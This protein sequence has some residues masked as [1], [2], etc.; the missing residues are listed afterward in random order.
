M[1]KKLSKQ[2][3]GKSN[4][5]WLESRF[6]FSFAEYRNPVNI[7][8]GVLRVLND[9]IVYPH[10]GFDMHPHEN[11]EIISYIV[12]GEITHKDSM[13][14]SEIL[15]RGEVQYLSAGDGIYHSEKNESNK[16]LR[17][18]QIWVFPPK[19]GLPR[20][21]GSHKY[22]LEEREN[23]LLNIVS[24]QNGESSIKIYQDINIYVSELDKSLEFNIDENRQIYFVQIEGTA[25]INGILL[26]NGD[27]MELVDEK[28]LIINPISKSHI[29]FIEMKK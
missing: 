9:D 16:D 2:N 26:E 12:D 11:M 28:Q 1:L 13:G 14:N 22:K 18:L 25:T 7:Q 8:F 23:R 3:M 20:L 15:K 24:S 4:L 17:L 27:A 21:Y 6:H 29:L 10:S 19:K 5:G